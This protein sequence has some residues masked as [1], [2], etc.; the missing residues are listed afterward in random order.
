MDTLTAHMAAHGLAVTD[1]DSL[2][3]SAP[4]RGVLRY[5]N[6]LRRVRWPSA[7]AAGLGRMVEDRTKR[8]GEVR[9]YRVP[10]PAPGECDLAGR[11]RRQHEDTQ[12][13]LG[14][15]DSR[16]TRCDGTRPK[17]PREGL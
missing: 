6:W 10:R 11:R 15:S 9:G 4:G 13:L 12:G 2:L 7:A 1:R 17:T 8:K 16:L 3:F 5:S 14:D